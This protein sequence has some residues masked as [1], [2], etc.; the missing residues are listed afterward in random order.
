MLT[1]AVN[2][3]EKPILT[4]EL[5]IQDLIESGDIN[6]SPMVVLNG[7]T[8]EDLNLL[9]DIPSEAIAEITV[10]GKRN[11]EMVELHGSQAKNGLVYINTQEVSDKYDDIIFLIDEELA[12][13]DQVSA[14]DSNT[15]N[16][17]KIF[18][19]DDDSADYPE[20]VQKYLSS[21]VSGVVMVYLKQE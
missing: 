11:P 19:L 2:A 4:A 16:S 9:K 1:L 20:V 6:S 8:L 3:Q 12:T 15:I 14:L 10:V 17:I 18:V 5:M 13:K 7:V 21:D